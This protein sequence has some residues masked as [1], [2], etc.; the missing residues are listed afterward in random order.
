MPDFKKARVRKDVRVVYLRKAPDDPV[1]EEI[2]VGRKKGGEE[3]EINPKEQVYSWGGLRFCRTRHPDG[4]VRLD[5]IA[6]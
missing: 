2:T 4:Y 1:E 6:L 5:A 3:I